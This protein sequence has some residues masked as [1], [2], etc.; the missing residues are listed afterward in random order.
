MTRQNIATGTT[1]N[2]GTG[3]TLRSAGTKINDNF[4]ELYQTF[5]TDSNTLGAGV[6]FE[7]YK[8]IFGSNLHPTNT[9]TLT[10]VDPSA[11]GSPV[12]TLPDSTGELVMIRTDNTVNFV[13]STGT[14]SKIY[15]GNVFA[16]S[17]ALPSATVY[18]GMFAHVHNIGRA[19]FA[20]AD[21]WHNLLDSDTFT[22][23]T[24]LRLND[25]KMD[26]PIFDNTG[27]FEILDLN[28]T[29]TGNTSFVRISNISDSAP[30][31]SVQGSSTNIG[32][33][34]EAKGDGP[35]KL[36]GSLGYVSENYSGAG[37]D[38]DSSLSTYIFQ[39]PGARTFTLHNGRFAGEI[40]HLVNRTQEDVT[41]D[42]GANKI[43][44][45]GNLTYQNMLLKDINFVSI[46]WDGNAWILDRDSD[47]YITF[48]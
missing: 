32:L 37:T 28:N 42:A 45:P 9:T 36:D 1:A 14:A 38:L 16:D 15:Y 39:T 3:D 47:K 7:E 22:S 10:R 35:I 43:R 25:P 13:D 29:S 44:T 2:D 5:G 34:I 40:K 11:S 26:T 48:S 21:S 23:R 12:L 18:H 8:I 27:N 4:V 33:N 30:T 19:V 24:G 41:I 17:D 31:L 46:I 20:H 6:E